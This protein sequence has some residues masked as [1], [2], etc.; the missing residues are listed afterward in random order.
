MIDARYR[1]DASELRK[2]AHGASI[3]V[4]IFGQ[5][6]PAYP[7][8]DTRILLYKLYYIVEGITED[9]FI[10]RPTS[11]HGLVFS[12]LKIQESQNGFSQL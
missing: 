9:H 5:A 7:F 2:S 1:V 3:F 6:A 12:L 10:P 8:S 4:I 11:S